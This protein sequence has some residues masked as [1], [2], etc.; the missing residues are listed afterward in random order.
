MGI[1]SGYDIDLVVDNLTGMQ[2][3]KELESD[4]KLKFNNCVLVKQ[5]PEKVFY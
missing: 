5:N 2:F 4:G 1:D 3:Y